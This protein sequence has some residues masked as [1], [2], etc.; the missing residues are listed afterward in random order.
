LSDDRGQPVILMFY[1]LDFSGTCTKEHAGMCEIMPTLAPTDS[2]VVGVSVDSWWAH[3]AFAA[4]LGIT[5]PLLADFHPKG[6]VGRMYGVYN[7]DLGSHNR[8]TFVIDSD[9]RISSIITTERDQVPD[10]EE[11]VDAAKEAAD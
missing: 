9:G 6:A 4:S 8:W 7:A 3:K 11:I 10:F 5:Y 2:V 1:P